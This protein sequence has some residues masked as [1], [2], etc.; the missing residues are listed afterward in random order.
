VLLKCIALPTLLLLGSPSNPVW[1]KH[2]SPG[3]Y[4]TFIR[5]DCAGLSSLLGV[6]FRE[7]GGIATYNKIE[8]SDMRL[9]INAR[10]IGNT[11]D[12]IHEN[13]RGH[14]KVLANFIESKVRGA[15]HLLDSSGKDG[16]ANFR[17]GPFRFITNLLLNQQGINGRWRT[18]GKHTAKPEVKKS[19]YGWHFSNIPNA[20]ECRDAVSRG[21]EH[22]LSTNLV[23]G[24]PGTLGRQKDSFGLIDIHSGQVNTNLRG[25]GGFFGC[26]DGSLHVAGL[27]SSDDPQSMSRNPETCRNYSQ[28]GGEQD[29]QAVRYFDSVSHERRPE[30]GSLLAA[31]ITT[32][33]GMAVG[34]YGDRF[35]NRW[36]ARLCLLVCVLMIL[37]GVVGFLLGW[38]IWSLYRSGG[39]FG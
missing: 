14:G 16:E 15:T 10:A 12:E 27:I 26:L 35:S 5:E 18:S 38:D 8:S 24:N 13:R 28:N 19:V 34:I 21:L 17:H 7:G 6:I 11:S 39:L 9:R 1:L 36:L 4:A 37:D 31:L 29:K 25:I 30:L 20:E 22:Q 33:S 2:E 23:Y 32:C 3:F